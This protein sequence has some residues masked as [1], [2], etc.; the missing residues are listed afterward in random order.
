MGYLKY[1]LSHFRSPLGLIRAPLALL[2]IT[3]LP[4]HTPAQ[5]QAGADGDTATRLET[6][7]VTATKRSRDLQGIIGAG[8]AVNGAEI[9]QRN[10]VTSEELFN[11]ISGL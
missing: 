1:Y 3:G 9:E 5:A 10:L 8:M 6:I 4:S 7:I 2:L 11:N